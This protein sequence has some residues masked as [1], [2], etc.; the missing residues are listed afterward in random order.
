MPPVD[1]GICQAQYHGFKETHMAK[2]KSKA[3]VTDEVDTGWQAVIPAKKKRPA[4][5]RGA[6]AK[7]P[8]PKKKKKKSPAKKAK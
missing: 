2:K 1:A 3:S 4:A 8:K 5:K 7:S 6:A